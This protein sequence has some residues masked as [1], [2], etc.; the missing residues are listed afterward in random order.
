VTDQRIYINRQEHNLGDISDLSGADLRRLGNVPDDYDLWQVADWAYREKLHGPMV[1]DEKITDQRVYLGP[2][3]GR[4]AR[5]YTAP[6][7]INNSEAAPA[8]TTGS[9]Q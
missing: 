1:T 5:F 6:K 2:G 7:F 4:P 9:D 3:G 8:S